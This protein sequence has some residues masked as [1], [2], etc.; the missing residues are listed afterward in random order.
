MNSVDDCYQD[1]QDF[2]LCAHSDEKSIVDRWRISAG[3]SPARNIFTKLRP[4][5]RPAQHRDDERIYTA[6]PGAW[7]LIK[8]SN[9]NA[10]NPRR[11]QGFSF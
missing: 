2:A 5:D 9:P 11:D 4:N 8:F 7:R 3:E 6:D 10:S 1:S